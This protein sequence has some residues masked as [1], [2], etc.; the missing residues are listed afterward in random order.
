[1]KN[2]TFHIKQTQYK[3]GSSSMNARTDNIDA[4]TY[5]HRYITKIEP[6][7]LLAEEL[8]GT[9]VDPKCVPDVLKIPNN[10]DLLMSNMKYFVDISE[11][12]GNER[13]DMDEY[14]KI[15]NFTD[16]RNKNDIE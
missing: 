7:G 2:K 12:Q 10:Y 14:E 15:L 3:K 8:L 16:E 13:V 5:S 11:H 6:E 4:Y 9:F 1:M